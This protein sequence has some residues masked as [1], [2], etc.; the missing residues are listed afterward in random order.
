MATKVEQVL[1]DIEELTDEERQQ[2][3]EALDRLLY[4]PLEPT[5]LQ[6]KLLEAG[7][8]DQIGDPR[9]RA[10]HIRSFEPIKL[11]GEPVSEQIIRERR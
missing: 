2:V 4:P 3:H 10:A 5:P 1:R 7:L 11:E 9:K 8:I 6:R